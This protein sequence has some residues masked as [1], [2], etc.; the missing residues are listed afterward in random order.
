LP[1]SYLAAVRAYSSNCRKYL[2]TS[3]RGMRYMPDGRRIAFNCSW[4]I[5]LM[6]VVRST[7]RISATSVTLS[8]SSVMLDKAYSLAIE[9]YARMSAIPMI[10]LDTLG[11]IGSGM[12]AWDHRNG[13]PVK[14]RSLRMPV[15][16]SVGGETPGAQL[17][18]GAAAST[19]FSSNLKLGRAA[20]ARRA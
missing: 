17:G 20:T 13:G 1:A 2:S 11:A 10:A 19:S 3:R 16:P 8:S 4:R 12:P 9:R 14:V 7:A 15:C 6:T 5:H 18:P